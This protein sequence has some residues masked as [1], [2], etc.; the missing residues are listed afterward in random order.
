MV[1]ASDYSGHH[2]G[3]SHEAYSFLITTGAALDEWLPLL[4]QFR[5]QFLPD[6]RRLSFKQLREPVRK[7]ALIP[8]LET[9]SALR[10]N[11]ITVL[12]DQRI[13]SFCQGGTQA[14][15]EIFPDCFPPTTRKGTIEK[16]V[17]LASFIAML[18]A[19]LRKED[20][21]AL[22][23]SDHDETLDT[24]DRREQLGRFVLSYIRSNEVA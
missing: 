7:R 19:G 24:F 10:G 16:M 13:E 8:F 23:I 4:D 20:Q 15:A 17:R 1:I 22:W 18:M 5:R 11:V 12:I 6:G 14:L 2:K 9:A 21:E 3:A